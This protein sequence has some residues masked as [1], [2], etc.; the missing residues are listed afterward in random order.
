[1][2][3]ASQGV[4]RVLYAFMLPAP[5][6]GAWNMLG[7]LASVWALGQYVGPSAGAGEVD[8]IGMMWEFAL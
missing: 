4:R 6:P 2:G 5:P 7:K 1:M 8:F 3:E